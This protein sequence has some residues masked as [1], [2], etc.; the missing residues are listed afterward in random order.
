MILVC[1]HPEQNALRLYDCAPDRECWVDMALI[2]P[3][4]RKASLAMLI[5]WGWEVIG[6]L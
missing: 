5:D 1:Y 3:P 4:N 2:F 6:E